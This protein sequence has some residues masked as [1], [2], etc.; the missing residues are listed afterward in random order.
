LASIHQLR[1][2]PPESLEVPDLRQGDETVAPGEIH[3]KIVGGVDPLG[4]TDRVPLA[5]LTPTAPVTSAAYPRAAAVRTAT[6]ATTTV[7]RIASLLV[8]HHRPV[9]NPVMIEIL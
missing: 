8:A 1:V 9:L 7:R 2:E 5:L 4:G 3:I 6:A